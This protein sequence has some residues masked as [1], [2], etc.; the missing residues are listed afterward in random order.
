[1]TDLMPSLRELANDCRTLNE[2]AHDIDDIEAVSVAAKQTLLDL[3]D[4]YENLENYYKH[5]ALFANYF[6]EHK[7]S[8]QP[9]FSQTPDEIISSIQNISDYND[10]A[11]VRAE[12]GKVT[13]FIGELRTFL[14]R[15]NRTRD[16]WESLRTEKLNHIKTQLK[17]LTIVNSGKAEKIEKKRKECASAKPLTEENFKKLSQV[18][19]DLESLQSELEN[20]PAK[21][22]EFLT[23]LQE[24]GVSVS[25]LK[26][27]EIN[28]WITNNNFEKNL[29][30]RIKE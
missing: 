25:Q 26:N 9:Q 28:D 2:K 30:V 15:E 19:S 14:A 10:K 11:L 4:Q 6:P 20:L 7:S 29:I 16:Q 22:K 23:Q 3:S 24:S 5:L 17:I 21:V 8:A 13:K 12:I 1:M 18:L 27:Q